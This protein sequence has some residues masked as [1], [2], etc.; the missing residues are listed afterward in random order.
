MNPRATPGLG[1]V[2]RT[3]VVHARGTTIAMLWD[4]L[5]VT[6]HELTTRAAPITLYLD[7]ILRHRCAWLGTGGRPLACRPAFPAL[8]PPK[9]GGIGCKCG[10]R[11]TGFRR[12]RRT[13]NARTIDNCGHSRFIVV[14]RNCRSSCIN[15]R[16]RRWGS[17]A[18]GCHL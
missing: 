17:W 5:F 2:G 13:E 10:A 14:N 9:S 6:P 1:T 18:E 4:L 8:R 7:L 12:L 15:L 11:G 16:R 3:G